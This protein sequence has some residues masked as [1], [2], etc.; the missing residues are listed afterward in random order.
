MNKMN[1]TI[2]KK[3]NAGFSI[4]LL[5][6][7]A[8]ASISYY[9]MNTIDKTYTILIN[10]KAK[11]LSMIKDLELTVK[12]QQTN[13][14]GYLLIED[15]TALQNYYNAIQNYTKQSMALDK[16][17]KQPQ[18][19]ALLSELNQI[20][21][22]YKEI[23]AKTIQFKQEKKTE[24]YKK[25]V[26]GQAKSVMERFS[27]K[28]EELTN[29]QQKLLN[30][31]SASTSKKVNSI[32]NIV[33][34]LSITAAFSGFIIAFYTA[35]IISKPIIIVNKAAKRIAD[36]DLTADKISIKNKDEIGELANSFNIMTANLQNIIQQVM[37]KTDHLAATS[38]EL[39]AS[40][41]QTSKSAEQITISIQEVS[42]NAEKQFTSIEETSL[43]IN[44]MTAGIS[45][46]S[47]NAQLVTV[48]AIEASAKAAEGGSAIHT[49]IKQMN[50]IQEKVDSLS[51]IIANLGN[52]SIEI[53]NI[54]NVITDISAQ[55]N[56]LA[57]N[58]AIEAARAGE[59]GRGFSVVAEE[60]RRLAEQSAISA[61]QIA[62]LIQHNQEEVNK[63][64]AS[65]D[66]ATKEV[67]EGI[68]TINDSGISFTHI[69]NSVKLVTT[70]IQEVS[71]AVQEIAETSERNIKI[72]Q[73]ITKFGESS[74][75]NSQ[76]V[77]AATEEQL[78]TMEEISSS[79]LSLSQMSEE[80]QLH[81]RRFK[82]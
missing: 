26:S 16:L 54:T 14:R 18:A 69:E 23:A 78:A 10:D 53:S 36:G 4:I 5:I 75:A 62:D 40:A 44:E 48:S 73:D 74:A 12:E 17:I 57:L 38:E 50:S 31:G 35:N 34:F 72:L 71:A 3:I 59:H 61:Q 20:E 8:S 55:T 29:Y 11:K 43:A 9:E 39:S 41:E 15:K 76:E 81:M 66:S 51:A 49:A 32:V 2:K 77:S 60:V 1:W 52:R 46:I 25:I 45:Q 37:V 80:L 27:L 68:H 67:A 64:I 47:N 13:L 22:E 70:Q 6:L 42:E 19:K 63:A 82:I 56:L 79:A 24:E 30:N 58:A 21:A 33:L 65:M 7:V 28:A